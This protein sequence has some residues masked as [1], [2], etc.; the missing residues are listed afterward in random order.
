MS[1][2]PPHTSTLAHPVIA[3]DAP[4]DLLDLA[5]MIGMLWRAKLRLLGAALTGTG[6]AAIWVI[7][8]A[9]PLYQA[10]TVL[11]LA[12]AEA[13]APSLGSFVPG[14][15][16]GNSAANTE[17]EA[18]RARSLLGRV[19]DELALTTDPEFFADPALSLPAQIRRKLAPVIP[20]LA[21]PASQMSD[22][23]QRTATIDQLQQV[24]TVRNVPDSVVFEVVVNSQ[25]PDKA[26]RIANTLALRHIARQITAK[27]DKNQKAVTWLATRVGEL[28]TELET[29]EAALASFSVKMELVTPEMHA[30][31][32]AN[33]KELRA[34]ISGLQELNTP[35]PTPRKTTQIASLLRLESELTRQIARQADD[36][37]TFQRLQSQAAAARLIHAQFLEQLKTTTAQIDLAQPDSTIL[38]L[39]DVPVA[40]ARPRVV[41]TLLFGALC[42]TAL[43]AI[44]VLRRETARDTFRTEPELETEFSLP[45]LGRLPVLSGRIGLRWTA[46]M[47][48]RANARQI[49]ALNQLRS[50][51]LDGLQPR[52]QIIAI[53]SA[54]PGEGR[55]LL[56][57]SLAHA[58]AKLGHRV[59]VIDGDLRRRGLTRALAEAPTGPD[60]AF[61]AVCRNALPLAD[62]IRPVPALGVD[63]LAGKAGS[64][65][66]ADLFHQAGFRRLL[67]TAR[68]SYDMVLIDTPPVLAVPDAR[69]IGVAA[70]AVLFAVRW[71]KTTATQISDA[72]RLLRQ[73]GLRIK[74]FVLT[75]VNPARQR[76]LGLAPPKSLRNYRI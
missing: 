47:A 54:L 31:L 65:N 34:K 73:S 44:G 42:L 15:G 61:D 69:I 23:D 59:L 21:A 5:A 17:V 28:Q 24:I 63:L 48:L 16:G 8:V 39:A 12:E 68:D 49:E 32:S 64:K 6:L 60:P 20:A 45:A 33:L 58:M 74:G 50:A 75:Q 51:V 62:A 14:L 41:L 4:A 56:T 72:L 57:L 3:P 7:W 30:V 9:V 11:V 27:I 22:T 52:P 53:T 25:D 10:T 66:P 55:S 70:D 76:H 71:D 2:L 29:H 38:S 18:L 36:M 67:R 37:I 26:A 35:S 1:S 40:P 43:A 46:R 19:V 13:V